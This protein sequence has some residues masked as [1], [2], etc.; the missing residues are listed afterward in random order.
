M[1][2]LEFKLYQIGRSD[3]KSKFLPVWL[4][5]TVL[6]TLDKATITNVGFRAAC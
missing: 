5:T 3:I 1:W 6:Q 4:P 2:S